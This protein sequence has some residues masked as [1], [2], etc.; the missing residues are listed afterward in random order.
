MLQQPLQCH[1]VQQRSCKRQPPKQCL[2]KTPAL[3]GLALPFP[4]QLWAVAAWHTAFVCARR[5]QVG[6]GLVYVSFVVS[7]TWFG[8]AGSE[9]LM[10]SSEQS[11]FADHMNALHSLSL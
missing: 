9:C 10:Q 2:S 5:G 11:L 6:P 7:G 8:G 3:H 4:G 1:Y